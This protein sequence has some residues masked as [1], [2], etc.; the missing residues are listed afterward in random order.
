MNFSKKNSKFVNEIFSKI[1]SLNKKKKEIFKYNPSNSNDYDF[2]N[3]N[4]SQQHYDKYDLQDFIK[5]KRNRAD[6]YINNNISLGAYMNCYVTDSIISPNFHENTRI[7]YDLN[8]Y[9]MNFEIIEENQGQENQKNES[10]NIN[11]NN[12]VTDFFSTLPKRP[13]VYSLNLK[14]QNVLILSL[15]IKLI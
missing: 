7:I 4:I 5:R 15:I 3:F 8:D 10:H 12:N 13:N 11:N 1:N 14:M 6:G 2:F 9:N